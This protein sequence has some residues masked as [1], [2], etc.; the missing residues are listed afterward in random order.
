MNEIRKVKEATKYRS[1]SKSGQKLPLKYGI[2]IYT[3]IV[4]NCSI[5]STIGRID[6]ITMDLLSFTCI[7]NADTRR[8]NIAY[9]VHPTRGN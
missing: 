9:T 7:S 4:I 5:K 3:L 6:L 1:K 8:G 2:S